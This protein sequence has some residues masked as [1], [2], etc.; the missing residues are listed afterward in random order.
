MVIFI[1]YYL[2]AAG[3]LIGLAVGDALGAPLE[4]LFPQ[5]V[6]VKRFISGG[7]HGLPA[8]SAT[9]DTYL[10]LAFAESLISN[11]GYSRDDFLKR[12]IAEY[13]CAPKF[14][15]PTSRFVFESELRKE[16]AVSEKDPATVLYES[17]GGRSGNGGRS[18]GSVMRGAPAGIFY[19][20]E[21]VRDISIRS[22]QITHRHPIACECTA[23]V[24]QMISRLVRGG[25]KRAAFEGALMQCGDAE[26]FEMLGN[27]ERY[28]INP[29][30]DALLTTHAAVS[31][32]MDASSFEGMLVNAVN[33][34]GDADTVGAICGALGGAYW[35]LESI[36]EDLV[37]GLLERER[38]EKAAFTLAE[39]AME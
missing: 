17:R 28:P 36:P 29:D 1:L 31:V 9:D 34:G 12:M 4:C 35:G 27:R 23:F 8:G 33:M 14:Y 37:I 19:P 11:R 32:F 38:I 16:S 13:L 5:S 7:V 25:E 24:N 10:A 15:G 21:Y 22:S 3:C 26:V 18:N 20:P 2:R 30:M 6:P 39:M